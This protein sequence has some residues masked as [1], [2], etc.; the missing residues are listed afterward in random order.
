MPSSKCIF[1]LNPFFM[2]V[3]SYTSMIQDNYLTSIIIFF[4]WGGGRVREQKDTFKTNQYYLTNHFLPL[5]MINF[6]FEKCW[7]TKKHFSKGIEP[8]CIRPFCGLCLFPN[9]FSFHNQFLYQLHI[10]HHGLYF[11][12]GILV[13]DEDNFWYVWYIGVIRL[14]PSVRK[15]TVHDFGLLRAYHH[16]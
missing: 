15:K 14:S 13:V 7:R 11:L 3:C 16:P 2:G 6:N 12:Q 4:S 1:I 9:A 10:L 5:V 8:K